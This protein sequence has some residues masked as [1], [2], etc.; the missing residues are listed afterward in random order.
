MGAMRNAQ[1]KQSGTEAG[2]REDDQHPHQQDAQQDSQ[3]QPTFSINK[4][5]GRS[6]NLA[7]PSQEE[8]N[9]YIPDPVGH[10]LSIPW[11]ARLLTDPAVFGVVVPD[12]RP[13]ASGDRRLVWKVFNGAG[14]VRACVTFFVKLPTTT[15]QREGRGKGSELGK[16]DDELLPHPL[17]KSKAL[18]RGGGPLDGENPERP[19]L[20]FNVLLDLGE[21]LSGFRG[22]LHGGALAVVL[23]EAMAAAA[24][25][26]TSA[27]FTASMSISFLKPVRIPGP[28]IVRSRIVKKQGRRIY[29]KG[30]VE[31]GEGN[32]MAESEA[33][34]VE[35][36]PATITSK[37]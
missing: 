28:V 29:V 5:G 26:Q 16:G 27:V 34:L 20:M 15:P 35:K 2:V 8:H 14:T 3:Q 37:F 30:A 10:F 18:L 1:V 7:H 19:F 31:D 9:Q 33:V 36:M 17:T 24:D 11:T 13:L 25:N 6:E 22:M 12:R 21:D 32:L 23:D 4:A